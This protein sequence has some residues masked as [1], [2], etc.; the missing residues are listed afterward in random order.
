L[1]FISQWGAIANRYA[2]AL[3]PTGFPWSSTTQRIMPF[4]SP[5]NG[6]NNLHIELHDLLNYSCNVVKEKENKKK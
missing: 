5:S 3:Y 4:H 1:G 2:A 6:K